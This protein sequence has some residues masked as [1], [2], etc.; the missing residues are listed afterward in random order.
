MNRPTDIDIHRIRLLLD[1]ARLYLDGGVRTTVAQFRCAAAQARDAA[2][3]ADDAADAIEGNT[4][5]D[6]I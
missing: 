4:E 5:G 2:T 1:Y 6:P 3:L